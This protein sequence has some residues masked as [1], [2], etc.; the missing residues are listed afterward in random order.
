MSRGNLENGDLA[1]VYADHAALGHGMQLHA[2][3]EGCS[4]ALPGEPRDAGARAASLRSTHGSTL[5]LLGREFL[6]A[7]AL[8]LR[9]GA[10]F[11]AI[12]ATE[13]A[14]VALGRVGGRVVAQPEAA[15]RAVESVSVRRKLPVE[16]LSVLH[17]GHVPP[18][19][20]RV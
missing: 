9:L 3:K 17:A 16:D 20:E 8:A 19:V 18:R 6:A 10:L 2:E 4:H 15:R 7:A 14:H 12:D 1:A 11:D 5:A 13:M